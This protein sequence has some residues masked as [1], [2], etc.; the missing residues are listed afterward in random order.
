MLAIAAYDAGGDVD[1]ADPRLDSATLVIESL[2]SDRAAVVKLFGDPAAEHP[3][4]SG[5]AAGFLVFSQVN[6]GGRDDLACLASAGIAFSARHEDGDGYHGMTFAACEGTF[7]ETASP[8]G[9]LKVGVDPTTFEPDALDL[10][11]LRLWRET[12]H[13]VRA[14]FAAAAKPP[15]A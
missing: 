12:E 4:T 9:Q 3:S 14:L 15:S 8:R 10:E 7:A 2:R 13:R 5:P 6:D 1:Q 11:N